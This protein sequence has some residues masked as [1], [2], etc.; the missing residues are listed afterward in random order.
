MASH[1]RRR[2]CNSSSGSAASIL[3]RTVRNLRESR[4]RARH[5]CMQARRQTPR[6]RKGDQQEACGDREIAA[7]LQRRS[8]PHRP[9]VCRAQNTQ[10][11]KMAPPVRPMIR[12]TPPCERSCLLRHVFNYPK[13][14]P[15]RRDRPCHVLIEMD[16]AAALGDAAASRS[17]LHQRTSSSSA[18][19]R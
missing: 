6:T 17:R 12:C 4:A 19:P 9:A 14:L 3:H 16:A 1:S 2:A 15:E 18:P 7:H 5:S 10:A 11:Q 8:R 13:F